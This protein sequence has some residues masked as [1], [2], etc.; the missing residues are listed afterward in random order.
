[1]ALIKHKIIRNK[2]I[3]TPF[4]KYKINSEGVVVS[5]SGS[6]ETPGN[7][8]AHLISVP[9]FYVDSYKA[10]INVGAAARVPKPAP[11]PEKQPEKIETVAPEPE[12]I[13]EPEVVPEPEP[14]AEPG[15]DYEKLSLKQLKSLADSRGIEYAK[16]AGKKKVIA[17]LTEEK[18]SS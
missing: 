8:S 12:A 3:T 18:P 4:G 14:V 7:V 13:P 5:E 6:A 9:G 15:I 11:E 16:N 17:L 10:K 1:M 2:Q